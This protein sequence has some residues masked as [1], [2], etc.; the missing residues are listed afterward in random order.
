MGGGLFAS[1]VGFIDPLEFG[2]WTSIRHVVFI[3]VGGL[4]SLTG[5]ILGA[6]LLTILPELLRG[7]KEYN[8]FVFGALLLVVLMAMPKGVVG[9]IR[10]IALY[11]RPFG[12]VQRPKS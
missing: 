5:S 11:N 12:V 3:V 6:A 9:L 7:F 8:E 10:D 4:G 2:V 1:L